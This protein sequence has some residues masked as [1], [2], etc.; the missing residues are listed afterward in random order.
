MMTTNDT[1]G[2]RLSS[3]PDDFDRWVAAIRDHVAKAGKAPLF[4]TTPET[5]L[6]DTFLDSFQS[7]VTR[8]VHNCHCCRH[9]LERFGG[10]AT[11]DEKGQRTPLFWSAPGTPWPYGNA[12]ARL[13]DA[14]RRAPIGGVFYSGESRFGD[15]PKPPKMWTHFELANPQPRRD[16]F[17][18]NAA[19]A[20][21]AK[22]EERGMVERALDEFGADVVRK[23]VTILRADAL[24]GGEKALGVAEWLLALHESIGAERNHRTRDA[25]VWL[26]VATAPAGFAHVRS[27]M[28]GTLLEDLASGMDFDAVKRRCAEKM[29][30]LQYRRPTAAPTEGNIAQAEK[31]MAELGAAGALQRRFAKI[32]DLVTTWT[33]RAI[34]PSAAATGGVFGHLLAAAKPSAPANIGAPAV[35]ITWDKFART[36][37][38]TAEAIECLVPAHGN[39][40]AFVTAANPA[41]PPM[42]QW[43][44]EDRRNPV[45]WYVYHGGS[46]A[47]AWNVRAGA[48]KVNAIVLN[49]AHWDAAR[50]MPNHAP[51][52]VFILDGARDTRH[53]RSGGMF[54]A[55]MRSEFHSIRSTLEAHFMRA[56][57]AGR[58]EATACGL[59]FNTGSDVTVV[60]TSGGVRMMY[61][62]DRW[63]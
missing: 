35:A 15:G 59:C 24:Y 20:A 21:A 29:H 60:V 12:A 4:T 61:R 11:I 8:Q 7:P 63:D 41:A 16:R 34:P 47:G 23:A 52:A 30:P 51:T 13:A 40:L 56:P 43:D 58:D 31:L 6:F 9:F 17:G 27:T 28:I 57:I 39:F 19:Q 42:V 37:L 45:T 36:V 49:P 62:L 50:A 38:P 10:L 48:V 1:A 32:E 54:P 46:P 22:L 33:P 25:L 55:H 3:S 5:P 53:E 14:V 18:E 44:R 26:A 2:P